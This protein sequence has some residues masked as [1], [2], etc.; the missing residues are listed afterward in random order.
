M[1]IFDNMMLTRIFGPER[2]EVAR[3]WRKHHKEFYG[4][5]SSPNIFRV[6]E[7]RNMLW[8]GH[9]ARM[10]DSQV[11]YSFGGENR[12][13]ETIWKTQAQIGG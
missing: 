2:D 13:K 4:L 6:T 8:A 9:V 12:G 11:L 7:S 5:F 10:G 1:R 3:E